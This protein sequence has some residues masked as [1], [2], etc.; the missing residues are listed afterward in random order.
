MRGGIG[1]GRI[2]FVAVAT[3]VAYG[4][5]PLATA[6]GLKLAAHEGDLATLERHVDWPAVRATLR[7][8]LR[9]SVAP[10]ETLSPRRTGLDAAVAPA[11]TAAPAGGLLARIGWSLRAAFAPGLIDNAVERYGSA[12]G[13]VE[14]ARQRRE[15][16]PRVGYPEPATFADA[17]ADLWRR[18]ERIAFIGPT[19]VEIVM[20]QR[21]QPG[22]PGRRFQGI[23]ELKDHGWVVTAVRV[24]RAPETR[25]PD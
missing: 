22:Q 8:S 24:V 23:L 12:R 18:I 15:W 14:L 1:L 5:W 7:Q 20:T 3:V 2:G 13:V 21:S 4:A 19:R 9:E 16:G 11:D 6:L 25:E 17:T 10:R